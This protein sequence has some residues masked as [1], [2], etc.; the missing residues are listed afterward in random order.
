[1]KALFFR[2]IES[3]PKVLTVC[4]KRYSWDLAKGN[5]G[6][7][8]HK[9][10]EIPKY[11]S[12]ERMLVPQSAYTP[13]KPG[14]ANNVSS[15]MSS[16]DQRKRPLTLSD[17]G[18]MSKKFRKENSLHTSLFTYQLVGVISHYG[19][20]IKSGHYIADSYRFGSVEGWFRYDDNLV[21]PTDTKQV[22]DEWHQSNGYIFYY[23]QKSEFDQN[24]RRNK[25]L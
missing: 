21:T 19:E 13:V 10:V 18:P 6:S 24:S 7:K 17:T 12:L 16:G 5:L 3:L 4:L 8:I 20:T 23:L 2:K 14:I 11:L 22:V 15:V 9:L 25:F 1:M